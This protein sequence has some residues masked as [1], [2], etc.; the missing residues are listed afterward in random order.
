VPSVNVAAFAGHGQLAFVSRGALW[1]LDGATMTLRLVAAPEM[2]PANPVF[3]SDGRWLAFAA[4]RRP[5]VPAALASTVWLAHGDGSGVH[6]IGP[7]LGLSGGWSPAADV[8]AVT[9]GNTIRLISP[10]GQART[11]ARAPGLD[12]AAWSPDGSALAVAA[13]YR[14]LYLARDR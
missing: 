11:L 14:P 5:P 7:G 13:C 2:R 1:V 12:S 4:I 6:P 3:S 8:L 9:A 10:S